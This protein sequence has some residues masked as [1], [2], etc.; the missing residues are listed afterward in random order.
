QCASFEMPSAQPMCNYADRQPL[1]P[2]NFSWA[3]KD[4]QVQQKSGGEDVG[5]LCKI[6]GNISK[7]LK[8]DKR[9]LQC[10]RM[11]ISL[12]TSVVIGLLTVNLEVEM[13]MKLILDYETEKSAIQHASQHVALNDPDRHNCDGVCG[14]EGLIPS[15][16][17]QCASFEMPSAQFFS[18]LL[19]GATI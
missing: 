1:A 6:F 5:T 17:E 19:I 9:L 8:H 10:V 14:R 18:L 13:R 7:Y 3:G 12:S 2:I 15:V 11:T 16:R 4:H